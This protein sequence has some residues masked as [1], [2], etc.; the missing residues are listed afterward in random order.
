MAKVKVDVL[1]K[2][3]TD[4]VA[5]I[6]DVTSNVEVDLR[7]RLPSSPTLVILDV[8]ESYFNTL[9][10]HSSVVSV[11][12]EARADSPVTYPSKPSMY[13]IADKSVGG[14]PQDDVSD[15][16]GQNY[17]SYQHYLDTDLMVAPERTVNSFTGSNVGNH[18][19]D[20]DPYGERDQMRFL[21][22]EPAAS[23]GHFGDDQTY[24]SYYYKD[25]LLKLMQ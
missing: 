7:N 9:E 10:S 18:Y 25:Y 13:T 23:S 2:D 20:S 3:G 8:E 19:Y 15:Q 16:N 21:G 5:F 24:S 6:N 12:V 1:L 11:Q 22:T 4:E 14:R 17:I